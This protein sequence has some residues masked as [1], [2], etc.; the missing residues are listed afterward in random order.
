VT[1]DESFTVTGILRAAARILRERGLGTSYAELQA[2]HAAEEI[3]YYL[4]CAEYET[5]AFEPQSRKA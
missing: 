5:D 2:L 3:D 1:N 4:R